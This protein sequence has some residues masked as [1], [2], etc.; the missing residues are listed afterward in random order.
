MNGKP[1][2]EAGDYHALYYAERMRLSSSLRYISDELGSI[3][4]QYFSVSP[5]KRTIAYL[6]D[7]GRVRPVFENG[8]KEGRYTGSHD[9]SRGDRRFVYPFIHEELFIPAF[10]RNTCACDPIARL[11]QPTTCIFLFRKPYV[12]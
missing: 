7:D 6:E 10:T 9:L 5:H 4:E 12:R 2:Q 8:E 11:F 3:L 1:I